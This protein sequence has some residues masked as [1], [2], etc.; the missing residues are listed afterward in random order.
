MGILRI[1]GRGPVGADV[2]LV[3]L[4]RAMSCVAKLGVGSLGAV[5][6]FAPGL[7]YPLQIAGL[8][9]VRICDNDR[10][11]TSPRIRHVTKY[12]APSRCGR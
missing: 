10:T 5:V 4:E 3:C 2:A 7:I 12:S 9:Q 8:L 6:P 1:V 11:V